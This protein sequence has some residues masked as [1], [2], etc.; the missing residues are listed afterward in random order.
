MT[1]STCIIIGAS[2]AGSQLAFSLR[3]EGWEGRILL[4]GAESTLPYHRP[5]LS[6][7]L[8][9][10][11]KAPED[12]LI[13]PAAMYEKNQIEVRLNT[14]VKA[15]DRQRKIV[16]LQDGSELTYEKLALATGGQLRRLPIP[17][18]EHPR[19]C[20]LRTLEDAL[21]L[22]QK[23]P[24]AQ[25]AV[26]IGGGYIGLETA[27]SFRKA[28]LEVTILE[29][30]GR[31]LERVCCPDI[32]Q[33]FDRIHQEEGVKIETGKMATAIHHTGESSTVVT[34]DG[35]TYEADLIVIGIGILPETQ[36]AEAAGLKVDRA[37]VVD[38]YGATSD[39]DI[40][41]AGD[42]TVFPHPLYAQPI[43]L[44]SVPNA[45][46][47]AKSA[48]AWLCGQ[49]KPYQA[50]PWFWSEQFD[51]KLQIAGLIAGYDSVVLRGDP[52]T[53]RSFAAFYFKGAKLLAADCVN[54]PK[55]FMVTRKL[56]EKGTSVT[57]EELAD[58][59]TDLRAL[60][61]R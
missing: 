27:A 11:E 6:K 36:L 21:A 31:L 58:E 59:T 28:G 9:Q 19:V 47:Q 60:M 24:Q 22:Q 7:E 53:S 14:W 30:T 12:I 50:I 43:H 26:I 20:Y 15:I 5:P 51:L 4:L 3:K 44:E 54:R 35:A 41:A 29:A 2:H 52:L 25:R 56:L 48:A 33:F 13:R 10:G 39:P 23:L 8:L 16:Q 38:Q 46:D 32:S 37:I 18:A 1:K 61:K 17:G 34:K 40:V 55:E 45:T 49:E 42:C 57:S